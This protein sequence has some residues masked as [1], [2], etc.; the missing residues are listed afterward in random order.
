M[1]TEEEPYG[2]IVMHDPCAD[3]DLVPR[4]RAR[5]EDV[6]RSPAER[7]RESRIGVRVLI[8]RRSRT[9]AK[10]SALISMARCETLEPT[11]AVRIRKRRVRIAT[12]VFARYSAHANRRL[13]VSIGVE[14]RLRV[15]FHSTCR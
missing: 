15:Y 3:P 9:L 5:A 6:N 2:Y 8:A 10:K 13:R 14:L 12:K 7:T 1:C 4:P 11:Y